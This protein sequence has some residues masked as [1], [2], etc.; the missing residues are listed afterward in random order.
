MLNAPPFWVTGAKFLILLKWCDTV[1][2]RINEQWAKFD[3]NNTLLWIRNLEQVFFFNNNKKI[4][5]SDTYNFRFSFYCIHFYLKGNQV[6]DLLANNSVS[7]PQ[8]FWFD[9]PPSLKKPFPRIDGVFLILSSLNL[10]FYFL[11]YLI[12]GYIPP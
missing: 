12:G 5:E 7:Y 6:S 3:I 4:G 11:Y 10:C 8:N 9:S 1:T 2:W